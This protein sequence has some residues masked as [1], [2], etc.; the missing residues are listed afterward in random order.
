[1]KT[2]TKIET[3]VPGEHV[4]IDGEDVELLEI[5]SIVPEPYDAYKYD[6]FRGG[7]P[8]WRLHFNRVGNFGETVT[9]TFK[10]F[11]LNSWLYAGQGL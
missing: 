10:D 5:E 4:Y 7:G 1:V 11:P 6:D 3:L 9:R 2:S 8:Y